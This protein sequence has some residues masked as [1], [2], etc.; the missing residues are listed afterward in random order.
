MDEKTLKQAGAKGMMKAGKT[1]VQVIIG[2][3]VQGVAD[4]TREYLKQK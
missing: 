3:K 2:L 4:A 1:G